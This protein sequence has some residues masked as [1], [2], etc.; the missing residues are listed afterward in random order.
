MRT[1]GHISR[2]IA[3]ACYTATGKSRE[4]PFHTAETF[5]CF[6]ESMELSRRFRALKL[7][8]SLQYHGR[9]A[10]REAIAQDLSHAQLL[11]QAIQSYPELELLAPV[12]LS[13]MC[14]RHREKDNEAVLK[15]VIARQGISVECNDQWRVRIAGVFRQP[16]HERRRC[17][18][19]RVRNDQSG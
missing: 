19:D 12:P 13:A 3:A 9:R 2:L 8:V 6:E 10:F 7:W 5:V 18:R 15:R 11:I 1:N 17:A 4:K 16:P 14:F